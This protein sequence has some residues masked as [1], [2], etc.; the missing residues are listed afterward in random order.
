MALYEREIAQNL[1][2]EDKRFT[3]ILLQID[4]LHKILTS[5]SGQVVSLEKK[6]LGRSVVGDVSKKNTLNDSLI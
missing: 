4:R 2:E 1:S 5:Q 3:R 6:I